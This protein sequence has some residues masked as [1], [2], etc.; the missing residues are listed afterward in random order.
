MA[1]TTASTA[2]TVAVENAPLTD[3][4]LRDKAVAAL[5]STTIGYTEWRKEGKPGNT[6]WSTA[7]A[8]LAQIGT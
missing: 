1:S 8:Y 3:A 2:S 6:K 7:L 5:E 4:Q